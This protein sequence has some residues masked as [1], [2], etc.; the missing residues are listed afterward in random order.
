MPNSPTTKVDIYLSF[1]RNLIN[2]LSHQKLDPTSYIN[3]LDVLISLNQTIRKLKIEQ[4][5]NP[6]QTNQI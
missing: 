2:I 3:V 1:E 5:Y 4:K 6:Q